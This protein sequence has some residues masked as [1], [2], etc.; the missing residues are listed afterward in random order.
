[1]CPLS[2]ML[3]MARLSRMLWDNADEVWICLYGD[4]NKCDRET[5]YEEGE[6]E[7]RRWFHS[8]PSTHTGTFSCAVITPTMV[9]LV[10]CNG[11]RRT[12]AKNK[13][14]IRMN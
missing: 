13:T 6:A 3:I 12:P 10:R 7:F 4:I 2:Y 14:T 5:F 11:E 8:E 9:R 1:M